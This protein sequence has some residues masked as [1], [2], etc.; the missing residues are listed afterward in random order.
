MSQQ[1]VTPPFT[2]SGSAGQ[3]VAVD[4]ISSRDHQLVK[5]EFGADGVATMVD[6][7]NPLPVTIIS[8][9]ISLSGS[10]GVTDGGGSLT[11]DNTGTFVVQDSQVKTDGGGFSQESDKVFPVGYVLD[12]TAGTALSENDIAAARIDSKRSQVVTLEDGTT[13]GRMLAI[14]SSGRITALTLQDVSTLM[15]GATALTPKF[16]FANINASTTDGQVV[17]AVASKRIRVLALYASCGSTGTDLTLNTKPAGAG[18]AI[19]AKFANGANGG[20]ILPYSQVGWFQT[21]SGEGLSATTGTGT[22]TGVG[23]V[24]VEV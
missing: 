20:E 6:A 16:A 15:S 21:N 17:A 9:G 10:I 18:S 7:S 11:V 1:S 23:V 19:S 5:I 8:G 4:R 2:G 12:D 22:A 24:Y 14:D 3:P 13:R